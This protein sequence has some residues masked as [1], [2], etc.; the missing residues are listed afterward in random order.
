MGLFLFSGLVIHMGL[1]LFL[2]LVTHGLGTIA[3]PFSNDLYISLAIKDI[4]HLL[5]HHFVA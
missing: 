4:N 3:I 1:F 2:D 5:V